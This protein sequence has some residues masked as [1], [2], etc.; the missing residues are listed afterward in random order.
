MEVL[1]KIFVGLTVLGLVSLLLATAVVVAKLATL[2]MRERRVTAIKE[3][4][5]RRG[6]EYEDLIRNDRTT[7][8]G[9]IHY[10]WEDR[11]D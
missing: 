10:E 6:R 2:A 11:N 7:F 3:Y 4:A 1:I 5:S 9:E 8:P